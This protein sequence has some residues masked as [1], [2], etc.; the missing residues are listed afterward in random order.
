MESGQ[1]EFGSPES[2]IGMEKVFL[3]RFSGIYLSQPKIK[4]SGCNRE[5]RFYARLVR[6]V[7][8]PFTHNEHNKEANYVRYRD[9]PTVTQPLPDG[10]CFGIQIG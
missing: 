4:I 3:V 6:R 5:P 9:I 2:G 8:T 1:S 7:R 10:F